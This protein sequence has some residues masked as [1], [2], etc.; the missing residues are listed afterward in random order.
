MLS[1][2]IL[3]KNEETDLPGCLESVSWSDDIHVF[4]SYSDDETINIAIA[5]DAKVTQRK[6]DGYASQRNAALT[7]LDFKY[8]WILI[9]DADER[10]PS[11]QA[12]VIK[13]DVQ[14]ADSSTSGFRIKRR[15]YLGK[16]WLRFSQITPYYTRIVRKGKALYH[17]EINE[18][19]EVNGEIKT[20]KGYFDHFPFSKGYAHWLDK[21]NRYSTMEAKR[22][23]E[24][25]QGKMKF[26]FLTALFSKDPAQRRYH[27][28]GLFYKIPGRP[29]IKWLYMMFGR[30]AF[31]DGKAGFIYSRLQCIYEYLIVI[32][33]KELLQKNKMHKPL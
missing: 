18:V 2:L 9:L 26:S 23:I 19:I 14:S 29:L 33:T 28:K 5:N 15:D 3:T 31:L 24:E 30:F 1:V 8:E 32:K 11:S 25:N 21:H 6:F 13:N 16:K 20:I 10:I 17:R 27:Q 12:E 7:G 22:W 4:D